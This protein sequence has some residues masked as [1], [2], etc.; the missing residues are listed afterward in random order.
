MPNLTSQIILPSEMFADS[1]VNVNKLSPL[2]SRISDL[3]QK[4]VRFTS[5]GTNQGLFKI[6]IIAEPK[7]SEI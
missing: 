4:W 7:C 3:G 6:I 5:Q 2:I 1:Y